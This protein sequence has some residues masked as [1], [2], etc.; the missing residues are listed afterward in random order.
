MKTTYKTIIRLGS[1]LLLAFSAAVTARADYQSTILSQNPVGYW[2]LNETAPSN[3][4]NTTATNHGSVVGDG[5]YEGSQG[6][7]RGFPGILTNDAAA[8]FDGTSQYIDT[9]YNATLTPAVFSVEG[10][11][12]APASSANCVLSCGDFASPRNGWLIYQTSATGYELRIYGGNGTAVTANPVGNVTTLPIPSPTVVGVWTHVVAT[13]DGTTAKIYLN[14]QFSAQANILIPYLPGD[15]TSKFTLGARAGSAF[16]WN[17]FED[18][19]AYYNTVLTPSVIAAHYA[20]GIAGN[21]ASYYSLVQS[22]SPMV[23]YRL[24]EAGDPP[25]A[26]IGTLGSS[27]QGAFSSGSTP[28]VPGPIGP[29]YPGFAST[30]TAVGLTNSSVA[31]SALN[32]NT[33]T[34]TI[35]CWVRAGGP[36]AIAA[37]IV[38]C[39]SGTTYS[40]L[41]IDSTGSYAYGLGYVWANDP[42]TYN[43]SLTGDLGLPTLN[44]SEWDYVAL[45]VQPT[46]ADIYISSP[47]IPFT[48]V[49]NY[50]N[51]ANQAFD[52]TTLFGSDAGNYNFNGQIDEVAIWNTSLTA[53]ALY[54]QYASAV[55]GLGPKIFVDL[56][57]PPNLL[58]VGDTLTLSVDVGGTP[59]LTYQWYNTAG[60][61]PGATSAVYT[62]VNAQPS[63]TDTYHL[64]ITNP[65]GI[66]TSASVHVTINTP[67]APVI[68]QAPVGETIYPG[69]TV[70]LSVVATGGGLTYQWKTNG[71]AIPGATASSYVIPSATTNNAGSYSVMVANTVNSASAGPV[72][73]TVLS[74][75]NGYESVIVRD[76][77][78]AWY[79]LD[80][81]SGTN[82]VDAM[83]RHNGTYTNVSG[84]PVTFGAAGCIV[85]SSDTAVTFHG[86]S[87]LSYG[88]VP[89]SPQLNT[90]QWAIEAWVKTTDSTYDNMTAISSLTPGNTGYGIW[91]T[92]AGSWSAAY[93]SG[94][95]LY[96]APTAVSAAGVAPGVWTHIVMTYDTTFKIYINGQWDN[97]GYADFD[98]NTAAPFLIGALGGSSISEPFD[99]QIDEVAV[100]AHP[101]T[102]LQA[103]QHYS[104]AEFPNPIPPYF[105]LI[106]VSDQVVSNSAAVFT[107]S[108][109]AN[110]PVP[111]TYQWYFNGAPLAGATS[112]TLNVSDTYS[113][114]GSYVLQATNPNGSTN[115][116][117]A[118]LSILPSTPSYVNVTNGLVLH[119]TFDGNYQDSS[120]RGNNGTPTGVNGALPSIVTGRIGS[121]AVSYNTDTST[122]MPFNLNTNAVVTDSSYVTLGNPADLQFG[123]SVDYSVSYWVKLP[124]GYVNGDLPF[125]CSAVGSS[126]NP[127]LTFAPAYTNGGWAFTY[128]GLGVQ[129]GANTINDGNW[130]HLI[131][132]VSRAGYAN[133]WLDG[134]Q[135]DSRLASGIGN[136]STAGPFNIGQDPTGLYPEQ[137]SAMVDDMAVWR[138]A[139]TSYE[140]Y[141]V[142]YAAT[143]SNSSFNIPGSVKLNI[144]EAGGNVVLTWNPGSTLGTLLQSTNIAGPWTPVGVYSPTYKV[145]PSSAEM[146]YR[147]ALSE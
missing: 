51:H 13:F 34:V 59:N 69:G 130:H 29:T 94:G 3:P 124:P 122:G 62:K 7:F 64:V 82:L 5:T 86:P 42:N 135:V 15:N 96:Y 6:F 106:P 85:G 70:N 41:T 133:T 112:P 20:A 40:G 17:G 65:Y 43:V 95:T 145:P 113:N 72:T 52:S 103:Q 100:Y 50:F 90:A 48:S 53:G 104:A 19:V 87:S 79:R 89:F 71:V 109:L 27:V 132:S 76:T 84:T 10:W 35:S 147:L 101:L 83:G 99:G 30:N 125:L 31:V 25:T 140:A 137:G 54:S 21:S 116:P 47:T 117:P 115:S 81:A 38:V 107:L 80:E 91:E 120:G 105:T 93:G 127:G 92:P 144:S 56:Q 75:T 57:A 46:E 39:D 16:Y 146:F 136:V 63:D 67:F 108:G 88:L 68:T 4:L 98:L 11:F 32:L 123:S 36:Q 8:Q 102:L 134:K 121:G 114:A 12:Y 37:G 44:D 2:R 77:P 28:G 119:L 118:T 131:H 66:A 141:S 26:N 9:P 24:D 74:P 14:G 143:N 111:I 78:E 60:M 49:T 22:S 23:Y 18:E 110:G 126:Y 55:G 139:L 61:I 58:Y 128:N 129:G 45:V 73:V 142:Y 97:G 1:A 138:R 33:N